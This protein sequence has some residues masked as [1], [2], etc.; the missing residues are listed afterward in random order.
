MNTL[1]EGPSR[2][3][4]YTDLR[5]VFQAFVGRQQEFN[6]L[7][8]NLDCNVFP[9]GLRPKQPIWLSGQELTKLVEQQ[10]IQFIWGVLSGFPRDVTLDLNQLEFEPYADGNS[11]LWQPNVAIQHP[12]A[13]V[14]LICWDSSA[15]LL[16]SQDDDLAQRFRKFFPEAI[17]LDLYNQQ[18][19][20]EE[21][22]RDKL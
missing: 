8:T 14:E 13:V 6:W 19:T 18:Q 10:D 21:S 9:T 11:A 2:M 15:T 7:I 12:L 16:L 20:T 1:L 3:G 22:K 4:F 5:L 17:D